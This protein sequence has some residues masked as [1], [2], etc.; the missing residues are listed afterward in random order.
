MIN[1]EASEALC[2]EFACSVQICVSGS[3]YHPNLPSSSLKRTLGTQWLCDVQT[4]MLAVL[5][6]ELHL[7][8]FEWSYSTITPGLLCYTQH[9]RKHFIFWLQQV[10]SIGFII[11]GKVTQCR[12]IQQSSP[13]DVPVTLLPRKKLNIFSW[14]LHLLCVTACLCL[15]LSL[16]LAVCWQLCDMRNQTNKQSMSNRAQLWNY[17]WVFF[18]SCPNNGWLNEMWQAGMDFVHKGD[19][20]T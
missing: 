20:G 1:P 9:K 16:R 13:P 18:Y 19:G 6:L 8:T 10:F 11:I 17:A 5:I 2:D 14:M 7:S 15:P 3:K 4:L 12:I